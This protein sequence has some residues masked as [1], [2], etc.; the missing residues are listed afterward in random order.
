MARVE[1][2]EARLN[3]AVE[4]F[5]ARPHERS[6]NHCGHFADAAVEAVTGSPR[7]ASLGIAVHDDAA[8]AATLHDRGAADVG[9]LLAQI[10]PEIAPA[11]AMRGDLGVVT[12]KGLTVVVV[13][14][15]QYVAAPGERCLGLLSRT[16]HLQRA[17]RVD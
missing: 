17:F 2:W 9:D 5:R 13:V 8:L 7:L 1:G 10:Y 3:N 12:R 6:Q 15:G 4:K 16:P 11:K 14:L